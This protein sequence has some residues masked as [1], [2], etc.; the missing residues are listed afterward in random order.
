V[1]HR[2]VS[3]AIGIQILQQ[4]IRENVTPMP[5]LQ[6]TAPPCLLSIVL[7]AACGH[8]SEGSTTGARLAS[9][10]DEAEWLLEGRDSDNSHFSPLTDIND[11]NVGNL[12]LAW[13]A[14]LPTEDGAVGTPL[15]ADG[16]VYQSATFSRAVANDLR[17]GKLLWDFRPEIHYAGNVQRHYGIVNRGV[18]LWKNK[19]YVNTSDCRLLALDRKS[20]KQVSNGGASTPSLAIRAKMRPVPTLA[21]C[22]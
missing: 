7:L 1:D 21:R 9:N 3:V 18:A 2:H 13:S 20:G 22:A 6:R 15:V 4:R 5:R 14:D 12:G 10:P 16:I 19:V 17:T 11:K 8:R